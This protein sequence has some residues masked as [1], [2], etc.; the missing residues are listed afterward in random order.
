LTDEINEP[1]LDDNIFKKQ[2]QFAQLSSNES[3]I[4]LVLL[5]MLEKRED[6]KKE[7]LQKFLA[8]DLQK[9]EISVSER[10]IIPVLEI[11]AFTPFPDILTSS[12]NPDEKPLNK[13]EKEKVLKEFQ[14]PFLIHYLDRYRE[15]GIPLKRKGRSEEVEVMKGFLSENFE[16]KPIKNDNSSFK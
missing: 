1:A 14:L 8:N 10:K 12:I 15:L 4:N 5:E 11:L 2:I 13:K 7:I 9:T 6:N 3:D 16:L